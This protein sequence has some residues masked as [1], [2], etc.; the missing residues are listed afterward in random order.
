MKSKEQRTGA[1]ASKFAWSYDLG[2]NTDVPQRSHR[3]LHT[4]E[5]PGLAWKA[6]NRK[7]W[8]SS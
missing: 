7:R 1:I 3:G 5:V 8:V 6:G 2:Y 4:P